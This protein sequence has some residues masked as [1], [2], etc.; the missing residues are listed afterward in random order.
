M[1]SVL[2]DGFNKARLHFKGKT[3]LTESNISSALEDIRSSLLE[4][5]VEYN[6]AKV[7]LSRV[8]EKSLGEQVKLVAGKKSSAMKVTAGD[9][10]VKICKD[11][12]ENLM[13]PVNV[14][15]NFPTNRPA[16]IMMVG[17]QGTGKT[18]TAAKLGNFL[19]SSKKKK[20]LLVAADIY[21]PAA[22]DQLR[23]L[24]KRLD[25]PVF[26]MEG[27]SP[28]EICQQAEKFAIENHCDSMIFDTA[29]RLTVDQELMEELLQ[30]KAS[31]KPDNIL[32]VCDA[33]MGQDAV[34]TATSFN[35]SLDLTGFVMTKLDGDAR[36]GA[37]LSIKEVTGKS[38]KF[39]GMGE[40]LHRLEEFRPEGLA[41]RIL[42]MGDV[43]GLMDDFE[44]VADKDTE[45]DAERILQG[46]FTFKDFYKQISMIQK[47]GSLKDLMAKLPMQG[48]MP[49]N[50]NIDDKQLHKIRYMIDSMTEK[51]RVN[52]D[53]IDKS[54][55]ERIAKGSGRQV[56]DVADLLKRFKQMR[57]VMG[58][59]G[60]NFG[61]LMSKI[62]GLNKLTGNAPSLGDLRQMMADSSRKTK[63]FAPPRKVDREKLKKLRKQAKRNRQ[64]SRK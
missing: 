61:G 39:L 49:E 54:R 31:T 28:V 32:L 16:S 45:K 8:K 24:G 1:L 43:V 27:K 33:M 50:M 60:K 9:H 56:K 63:A 12:L 26:H 58:N 55:V 7:F 25:I 6:V 3:T 34:H 30:I 64:K 40:D 47:M 20:P 18:T 57:A 23:V 35:K 13:G 2:S 17:L 38:I 4:A 37:A 22:V 15:L 11:E 19:K 42:G 53:L 29:G 52:P 41:S 21:R 44:K 51:E 36:G 62:P 59:M 48:A 14:E 5:D 10:F 46:N